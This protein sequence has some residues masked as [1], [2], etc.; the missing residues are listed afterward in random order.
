M[1]SVRL[2]HRIPPGF[3]GN[4]NENATSR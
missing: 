1:A 2:P 3:H 4:W